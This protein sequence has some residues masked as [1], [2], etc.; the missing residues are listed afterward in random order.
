MLILIE[1]IGTFKLLSMNDGSR[2][3]IQCIDLY[4]P[5]LLQHQLCKPEA[6]LFHWIKTNHQG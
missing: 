2:G 6:T 1:K 5:T 3:P 4:K